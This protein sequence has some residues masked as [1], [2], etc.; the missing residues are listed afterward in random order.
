LGLG[1]GH[2]VLAFHKGD[3]KKF[4]V[5]NRSIEIY[6]LS[7]YFEDILHITLG[8]ALVVGTV[9]LWFFVLGLSAPVFRYLESERAPEFWLTS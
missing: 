6:L 7:K 5:Y 1:F 4:D 2:L 9:Y 8:I 3:E